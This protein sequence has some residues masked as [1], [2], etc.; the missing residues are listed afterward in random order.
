M[1][2]Q[3]PP[4]RILQEGFVS[5]REF[6][7]GEWELCPKKLIDPQCCWYK[8]AV[9]LKIYIQKKGEDPWRL[10]EMNLVPVEVARNISDAA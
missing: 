5:E 9:L 6:R 8:Q 2:M 1:N 7:V 10:V 4:G 3:E